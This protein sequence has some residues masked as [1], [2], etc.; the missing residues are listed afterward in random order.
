ML[1]TQ[2]VASV[3]RYARET[4]M[5][6]GE[7]GV[8]MHEPAVSGDVV[9]SARNIL[10][11]GEKIPHVCESVLVLTSYGKNVI[12]YAAYAIQ[13]QSE[14][15]HFHKHI[16]KKIKKL[17]YCQIYGSR[18]PLTLIRHVYLHYIVSLV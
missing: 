17:T 2:A 13:M 7:R 3:S 15:C 18:W 8:I 6:I 9:V 14:W 1:Q 10:I 11:L 5:K 16:S 12:C 4:V